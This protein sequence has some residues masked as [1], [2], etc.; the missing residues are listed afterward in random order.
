MTKIKGKKIVIVID[1]INDFRDGV[2][3]NPRVERIIPNIVDLLERKVLEG[4][5]ALFLGDS[6]G[7][8]DRELKIFPPHGMRGT[9]GAMIIPELRKFLKEDGSNYIAKTAYAGFMRTSL[10]DLIIEIKPEEIILVGV[11]TD[12]CVLHNA[13]GMFYLLEGEGIESVIIIPKDCV[14]TFDAP[15]HPAD[16][17]NKFAL[18]HMSQVLGFKVVETQKEA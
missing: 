2:F 13:F 17:N 11:C 14:E 10:M 4:Y 12:I 18:A 15:D 8:D 1:M 5:D 6:H 7:K 3:A 9:E 16:M